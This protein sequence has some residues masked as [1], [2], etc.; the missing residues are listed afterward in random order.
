M[1][2]LPDAA[3]QGGLIAT[4]IE[5]V[6]PGPP[7]AIELLDDHANCCVSRGHDAC[8]DA[9]TVFDGVAAEQPAANAGG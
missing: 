7:P 6:Q 5:E 9:R 1:F 8:E 2:S 4:A 3:G